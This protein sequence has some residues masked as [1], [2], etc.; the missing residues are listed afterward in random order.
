METVPAAK[1]SARSAR[2]R[3]RM[4][5]RP[6]SSSPRARAE[7]VTREASADPFVTEPARPESRSSQDPVSNVNS[8]AKAVSY[9][10]MARVES[11]D[12][13]SAVTLPKL[14]RLQTTYSRN[15]YET[16]K[17][18]NLK[19]YRKYERIAGFQKSLYVTPPTKY[20]P[21]KINP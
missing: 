17:V 4:I 21:A 7:K 5:T 8:G 10:S 3:G 20:Q 19:S 6:K 1:A 13:P 16:A 15:L 14:A 18:K 2:T 9:S 12:V 11:L